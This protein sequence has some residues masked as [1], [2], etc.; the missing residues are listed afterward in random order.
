MSSE[1]LDMVRIINAGI[2]LLTNRRKILS[3]VKVNFNWTFYAEGQ[4]ILLKSYHIF[5]W[6]YEIKHLI[7]TMLLLLLK[8]HSLICVLWKT[9]CRCRILSICGRTECWGQINGED[10]DFISDPFKCRAVPLSQ[11]NQV[12]PTQALRNR[13]S[14][15]LSFHQLASRGW[16]VR[17]NQG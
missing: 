1:L 16:K 5:A 15:A 6:W 2:I 10:V 14:L 4:N 7:E 13:R 17:R 12:G 8:W 9:W 3:Q 11:G